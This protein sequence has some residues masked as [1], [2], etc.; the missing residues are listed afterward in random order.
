M[1]N[2]A[3]HWEILYCNGMRGIDVKRIECS[4]S[5]ELLAG[6]GWYR[7]V[8]SGI[9]WSSLVWAGGKESKWRATN[10]MAA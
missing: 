7:P 8:Q 6:V 5:E 2:I 9:A 1:Q 3:G 4:H 10:P